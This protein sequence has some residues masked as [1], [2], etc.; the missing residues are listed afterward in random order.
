MCA[1]AGDHA[2]FTDQSADLVHLAH[3][4]GA[5][6]NHVVGDA[7]MRHAEGC[8]ELGLQVQNPGAGRQVEPLGRRFRPAGKAGRRDNDRLDAGALFGLADGIDQRDGGDLP[9]DG[10]HAAA[11]KDLQDI[12]DLIA[13][14]HMLFDEGIFRR[15][16]MA[17]A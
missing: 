6:V 9:H 15:G 17:P 12:R 3:P 14:H 11:K 8:A 13:F 7:G 10:V 16:A 4:A 1:Q 5:T 2:A